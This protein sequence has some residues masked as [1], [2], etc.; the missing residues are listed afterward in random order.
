MSSRDF[1]V[2]HE[3]SEN[4]DLNSFF[5]SWRGKTI[6]LRNI[7]FFPRWMACKFKNPIFVRF[8]GSNLIRRF[9][10]IQYIQ[11][12]T[13][14][15]VCVLYLMQKA[16][17]NTFLSIIFLQITRNL[18]VS[19]LKVPCLLHKYLPSCLFPFLCGLRREKYFAK[20][21]S[22]PQQFGDCSIKLKKTR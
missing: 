21:V 3:K 9:L 11:T 13:Y 14:I 5:F 7:K 4:S 2:R 18:K 16:N 20:K 17:H 6:V 19:Y 15:Y 22:L 12:R 10:F 8:L 1:E